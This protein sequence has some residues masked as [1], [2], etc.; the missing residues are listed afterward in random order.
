MPERLPPLFCGLLLA[1][2]LGEFLLPWVLKRFFP[3]YSSRTMVMSVLGS[4]KSPVRRLYNAWLLW[5]GGFL[6]YAALLFFWAD[7]L[8][9]QALSALRLVCLGV[10]ALGGGVLAGLFSVGGSKSEKNL[11][12]RIHGAGSAVGFM[13]LLFYPL[14]E[15]IGWFSQ[16]GLLL[17]GV[18]AG[19]FLLALVFFTFFVLADKPRF[20]GT[21]LAWEGLW[22]R[23]SLACMYVPLALRAVQGLLRN[24]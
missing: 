22:Q 13:A 11:A 17:G 15:A 16:G 10:F 8:A 24:L 9:A 14:L 6:L 18:C 21:P 2:I 23:A 5:L 1:T 20:Q 19:A 4:P 3:G 12:S 7:P